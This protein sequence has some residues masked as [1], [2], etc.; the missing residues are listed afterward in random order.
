MW[1][2]HEDGTGRYHVKDGCYFGSA[3]K[4]GQVAKR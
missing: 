2:R 4:T 3:T 1:T